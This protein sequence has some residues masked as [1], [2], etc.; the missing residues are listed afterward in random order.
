[1]RMLDPVASRLP[2][3]VVPGNHEIELGSFGLKPFMAYEHRFRMPAVREPVLSL[4]CGRGGGL[5]GLLVGKTCGAG[6]GADEADAAAVAEATRLVAV[7]DAS[8]GEEVGAAVRE[9]AK[10][11]REQ[12][13][14]VSMD[15]GNGTGQDQNEDDEEPLEICPSEWSGTY[16]YGSR[17]INYCPGNHEAVPYEVTIKYRS[18]LCYCREYRLGLCPEIGM[19]P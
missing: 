8:T 4:A 11:V 1:M 18:R 9:T 19:P 13:G 10:R 17:C 7:G 12:V 16:D 3:M 14:V 5:D 2:W 15:E 6:R